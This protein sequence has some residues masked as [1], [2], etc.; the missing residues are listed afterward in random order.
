[1][2]PA[3][4]SNTYTVTN[5]TKSAVSKNGTP[6]RLSSV[7]VIHLEHEYGAHK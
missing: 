4:A 2:S 6:S 5:T 1:M 3:A 7:E